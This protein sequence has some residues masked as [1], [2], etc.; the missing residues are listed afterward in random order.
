MGGNGSHYAGGDSMGRLKLNSLFELIQKYF[1]TY[2]P[3]VKKYSPN[4]IRAY[5]KALSMF[6][7]YA[8]EK[9][10]V[11]LRNLTF[12]K[13]DSETLTA[14]LDYLES[15]LGCSVSTRNHRLHCIRTFFSFAAN[16][17]INKVAYWEDIKSVKNAKDKKTIVEYM[18][19]TAVE[20]IIK[21]PDSSTNKGLQDMFLLLFLYHTAA[22]VQELVDIQ[23]HDIIIT[24]TSTVVFHGKGGKDRIVP[25]RDNVV[26]HLNKYLLLFHKD[27]KPTDYL[28]FSVRNGHHKRMTE[29]NVRKITSRY[30]SQARKECS[31]VPENVHPHLFRHSRAMHLYQHGV[32]L[33]LISQ[34]LGHSQLETTLIYAHADTEMKRKAIEAS[35]PE[36]SPLKALLNSERMTIDDDQLLKELCGLS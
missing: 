12:D 35:V 15:D 7:D 28:F 25:I 29:D 13:L 32:D 11:K 24:K 10:G 22:R 3:S 21:Q 26:E 18:S 30:G 19:E 8:Q 4:T 34:W 31:D 36:E 2:L 27:S 9:E 6:L 17:D 23:L 33:T 16:E 14:F 20:A 5:K 1:V